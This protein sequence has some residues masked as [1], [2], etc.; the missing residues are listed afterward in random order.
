MISRM[1]KLHRENLFI[2][3]EEK[4]E[5]RA[6]NLEKLSLEEP[7]VFYFYYRIALRL[8]REKN[9]DTDEENQLHLVAGNAAGAVLAREVSR[10]LFR[11]VCACSY[12]EFIPKAG[13]KYVVVR[14]VVH[15]FYELEKFRNAALEA[16]GEVVSAMS[17]LDINTG[18]GNRVKR[19][20]LYTIDLEKGISYRLKQKMV[21]FSE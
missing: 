16:G 7:C 13:A 14:D 9:C 2:L 21:T 5:G 15:A 12:G 11:D 20:S 10:L 8:L 6:F 1:R 3:M 19:I 17:L 4:P 18:V